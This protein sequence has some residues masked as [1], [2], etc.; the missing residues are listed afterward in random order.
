M[1]LTRVV[2]NLEVP[3]LFR[4]YYSAHFVQFRINLYREFADKTNLV[5]Y[6]IIF[7]GWSLLDCY[8]I[9]LESIRIFWATIFK[10]TNEKVMQ[11]LLIT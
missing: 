1:S 5:G 11:D 7:I 10:M 6:Y 4:Y 3:Q 8:Q 2:R 9:M